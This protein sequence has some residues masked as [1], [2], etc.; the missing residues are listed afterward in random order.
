ML[1]NLEL[2][3]ELDVIYACPCETSFRRLFP[4][5]LLVPHLFCRSSARQRTSLALGVGSS[6]LFAHATCE[7]SV[8][9]IF[10]LAERVTP[11]EGD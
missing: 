8:R 9:D 2:D 3:G 5:V 6:Q 10:S 7:L 1:T 11:M 4:I